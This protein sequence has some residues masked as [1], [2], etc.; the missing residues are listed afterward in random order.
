MANRDTQLI[1]VKKKF[2][3]DILNKIIE[4][5]KKIGAG[6]GGYPEASEI[7]RIRILKAGGI[8]DPI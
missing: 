2:I 3:E 4:Q 1:R 7:L 8:K 6:N 5:Q